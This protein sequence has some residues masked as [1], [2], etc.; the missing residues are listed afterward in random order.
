MATLQGIDA[1]IIEFSVVDGTK[2]AGKKVR[3]IPFPEGSLVGA[4]ERN[5]DAHVAV[6]DSMV[7]PG[8]HLVVFCQPKAV[9][10]LNK[11]FH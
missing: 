2:V 9:S 3:D 6:G 7:L 1:E 8:D 11:L 10:K 4:I 5:E